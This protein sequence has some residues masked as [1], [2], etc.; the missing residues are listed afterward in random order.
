MSRLAFALC[1]QTTAFAAPTTVTFTGKTGTAWFRSPNSWSLDRFPQ[2]P[3]LVAVPESV[4]LH[5]Q[6]PH[7]AS[8]VRLT[9]P[10]SRLVLD[11]NAVL[12]I[13]DTALSCPP[14]TFH[15][16]HH[17][18]EKCMPCPTG[19]HQPRQG[20]TSCDT[21]TAGSIAAT[22][23]RSQCTACAPG[24]YQDGDDQT[25]C[26]RHAKQRTETYPHALRP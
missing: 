11:K 4:T 1:L 12:V 3:D 22:A 2:F 26:T 10:Q 8:S 21:C 17:L 20:Q 15:D 19:T 25:V 5:R 18:H 23:G 16:K 9:T 6:A 7:A 13:G 24:T 14:G